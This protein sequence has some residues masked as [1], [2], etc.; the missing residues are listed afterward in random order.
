MILLYIIIATIIV[1]LASLVGLILSS[2]HIEKKLHLFV[3]FAAATLLA[4]SFFDLIPHALFE[5]EEAGGH[6]HEATGFILLGI[7]L[8]FL[9]ERFIHWHHCGNEH[10]DCSRK[11]KSGSLILIGDFVHNFIDGLLIAGAFL[12][13]PVTGLF[14]T[15]TVLIHEIPQEFGDFA[16]LLHSG[17][18]KSKALLLNFYSA[19]SAVIGGVAGYFALETFEG[20]APF[21]VLIAAGGFI[22]IALSDLVP[23]LHK[24][25]K[26]T[27]W[28]ETTIFMATI[29]F[30]Y[31]FVLLLH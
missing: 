11:P 3:T 30:F 7:I 8:F 23:S 22:Y 16:V 19:L 14:T 2:R 27:L 18:S 25:E 9:V 5:L 15:I 26:S 4:V 1:S 10:G 28:K 24:H 17:Y 20:I 13:S 6:I 12:I 21:A 31:Y 29:V